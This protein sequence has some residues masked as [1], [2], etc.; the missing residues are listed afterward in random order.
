MLYDS[1]IKGVRNSTILKTKVSFEL[2]RKDGTS[3][4]KGNRDVFLIC[5]NGYHKWKSMIAPLGLTSVRE[6]RLWSEGLESVR[7]DVECTFGVMKA[8]F[9][10]LRYE[11][12]LHSP[13]EIE[14]LWFCCCILHNML[15]MRDGFSSVLNSEA[16]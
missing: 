3:M 12:R 16:A 2:M 14:S 15:L 6:E 5:D 8:R 11:V 4:K 10:S 1:H 7:K 13:H 9:R